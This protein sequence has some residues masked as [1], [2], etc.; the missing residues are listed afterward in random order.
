MQLK[1]EELNYQQDAIQSVVDIFKGTARN[2]FENATIN[3]IRSNRLIISPEEIGQNITRIY[4]SNGIA[5]EAAKFDCP[6]A[7]EVDFAN[8]TVNVRLPFDV[9]VE[10]ETGTGKTIVYLKTLYKL[11]AEYAFT[12]FIILVPSIAIRQGVLQ[13][14]RTF[15][16]QLNNIFD[17]TPNYFEYD[18]KR[19]HEVA[20]FAEEQH[21]QIMVATTGSIVGDNRILNREQ[22]EDLFDNMP[23]V[24][25]LAK[26]R[27]VIVMDE[28]QVGMDAD[29]TREAIERL[30][31]L[32]RLR[33]S[34]TH[35]KEFTKNLVYRL[36]P[37]DSYKQGLVKKIDVLTVVEKNDEASLKIELVEGKN[38]GGTIKAKLKVWKKNTDG[39]VKFAETGWL[40]RNDD[41]FV[42]TKN[43][44][45]DGYVIENI[46]KEME[47]GLW[48]VT[49]YNKDVEVVERQISGNIAAVWAMQ[50]QF[51]VKTHFEKSAKLRPKGIKCLSL[52]FINRVA[53]Y[54]GEDPIIKNLFIEKYRDLYPR[55]NEGRAATDEEISK[56]QGYY[57]AQKS[58]GELADN[59]G[60]QSEQKR[61]YDL[62]LKDKQELLSLDNPVEFI[63]SHSALGVGWD[64]P[65]VFNIATLST[66]YS[67]IKKRQ[68]IGR[69]LRICVDQKGDRKY[70]TATATAEER[71]NLLTVIPN[72]TYETFALQYQDE[73]KEIY[74]TVK[75]GAGM[76]HTDK[77][78]NKSEVKFKRSKNK[79]V[80]DALKA[81][82]N[83]LAKKTE[84]SVLFDD[85]SIIEAAV[86]A[87][88]KIAIPHTIIEAVLTTID[89]M[90][91]EGF[92]ATYKGDSAKKVAARFSSL[93]LIEELS[94]DTHLSYASVI[95]IVTAIAKNDEVLKQWVKNPPLFVQKAAAIIKDIELRAM[96]RGLSYRLTGETFPFSFD[97]YADNVADANKTIAKT[98]ERGV[99]D[100]QKIDSDIEKKF[101]ETADADAQV[102]CVLKLPKSYKVP[103]PIGNYEPDFGIVLKRGALDGGAQ[104]EYH[105]VVETKATAQLGDMSSLRE[106][107]NFKMNCAFE[108]FRALGIELNIKA[109]DIYKAPVKEYAE[110]KKDI[111]AQFAE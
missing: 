96:L 88:E 91:E 66:T 17:V 80:N 30:N 31:P 74:G 48:R 28:P 50:M 42:K 57:F 99:Y 94:D 107:E 71:T 98:P 63:F 61:I 106:S 53:N 104:T 8:E 12:K 103:T 18:S 105:Y 23:F 39:D 111:T 87:M 101:A 10:M 4:K 5:D 22:R 32:A 79:S 19:I 16:K 2:T 37:Y 82:W 11:Y 33:Y 86:S 46:R 76:T 6:T 47:D 55:F 69:G 34:A 27:P 100:N 44:I 102:V 26:T 21:P 110:F 20:K 60:G 40:K 73:I 38:E 90:D 3:G 1:L 95:E 49:F 93:D 92:T 29:K 52:V 56:A 84:Y 13:T 83:A 109:E 41:L 59:E 78:E 45:Y 24:D 9:C 62:I 108:H 51:L 54:I 97:D 43:I 77:G 25:L 35:R 58:T 36:T 81:F 70:D 85:N 64:N 7:K 72:E 67:E 15:E 65:N 75:A 14:L 89:D 68:E